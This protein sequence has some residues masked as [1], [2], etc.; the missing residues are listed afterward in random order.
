MSQLVKDEF[1]KNLDTL[2]WMSDKTKANAREKVYC[3]VVIIKLQ[4]DDIVAA[5]RAIE[6][7]PV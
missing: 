1:I 3:A 4:G 2:S 6:G 7:S 5:T